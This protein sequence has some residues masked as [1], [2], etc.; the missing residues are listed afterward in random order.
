MSGSWLVLPLSYCF[1]VGMRRGS[2]HIRPHIY[3]LHPREARIKGEKEIAILLALRRSYSDSSIYMTKAK[4]HF[5]S[6]TLI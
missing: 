6:A 2:E 4:T 5:A 3:K 1:L